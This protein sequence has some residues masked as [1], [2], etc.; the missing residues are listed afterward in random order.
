MDSTLA[1]LFLQES[2]DQVRRRKQTALEKLLPL[3][4]QEEFQAN[5]IVWP[6][7]EWRI[8]ALA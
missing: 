3:V 8:H 4:P 2:V 1:P 7:V 5:M 6:L